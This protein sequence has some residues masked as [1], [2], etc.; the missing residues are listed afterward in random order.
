MRTALLLPLMSVA[1]L[2]IAA[3]ATPAPLSLDEVLRVP[4]VTEVLAA[5]DGALAWVERIGGTQNILLRTPDGQLAPLTRNATDDGQ[6]IR[7]LAFTD[8]G[9]RLLFAQGDAQN[10]ANLPEP[11][12]RVLYTV[13]RDGAA[14]LRFAADARIAVPSPDGRRLAIASGSRVWITG[15]DPPGEDTAPAFTDRGRVA[16]L[17]W[18]PDG[19]RLAF[20][21]DRSGAG[22]GDYGFIG[23]FDTAARTLTYLAPGIG[24]DIDPVWSPDSERIAF[25]RHR[26]PART[27]RF[28][29]LSAQAPFAVIVADADSGEARFT[30]EAPRGRGGHFSGFWSGAE[31]DPGALGSLFWMKDGSLIFPGEMSG[32][33]A[34]YLLDPTDGVLRRLTDPQIEIDGAAQSPDRARLVYW[35]PSRED[36]HRLDL[37]ELRAADALQPQR[38]LAPIPATMRY[39]AVFFADGTLAWRQASN[40]APERLMW[41]ATDGRIA[42][43]STPGPLE[44]IGK[45]LREPE[46]VSFRSR[47]G[48]EIHGVLYRSAQSPPGTRA[49]L[50]VHVH[51][52]SRDKAWPAWQPFFGYPP[53][54]RYFLTRGFHVLSVNYRSGTGDGLD[55]REAARYGARGNGDVEDLIAAAGF[56]RDALDFVD[57]ARIIAYGH[58]YG[59]HLVATALAQSDVFAA[60]IDSA[61]ISDWVHEMESDSGAPLQLDIP[62]RLEIERRAYGYSAIAHVDTWG[63]EPILFLHGDADRSAAMDQTIDLYL[64]LLNR[65]RRAEAVIF[66][67]EAHALRLERNQR[68]YIEA[69]ARF[70]ERYELAPGQR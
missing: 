62:Q 50:I 20:V 58:S 60:G 65:G 29:D 6:P 35:A 39:G 56:A 30:W 31:F 51:G 46:I 68:R 54:L 1:L 10:A 61:G 21:S 28:D 43:L 55:F 11:T 41:R 57:P 67:G 12:R 16:A 45:L 38:L 19:R 33:R 63:E 13:A 22:R 7:L 52:G 66:P 3:A 44:R 5:P 4:E 70:L 15:G 69:I 47:D 32:F 17:V 40:H 25:I 48:L 18:S 42:A 26:R 37:Y 8:G 59:G 24:F 14:P 53:V 64:A 49:P 23:V 27:W 2:R 36:R 34:L 9:K